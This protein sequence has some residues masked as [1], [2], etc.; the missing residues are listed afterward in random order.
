LVSDKKRAEGL[1]PL[2]TAGLGGLGPRR[3]KDGKNRRSELET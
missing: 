1:N 2:G 3:E